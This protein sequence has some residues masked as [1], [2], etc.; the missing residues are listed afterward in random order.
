MKKSKGNMDFK[1]KSKNCD[2]CKNNIEA[3]EGHTCQQPQENTTT[4]NDKEEDNSDDYN[5]K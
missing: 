5:V 1:I 3:Q 2:G 4:N